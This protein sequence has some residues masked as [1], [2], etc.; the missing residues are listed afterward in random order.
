MS[1]CPSQLKSQPCTSTQV[2][3]EL[4]VAH[5]VVVKLDPVDSPVHHWPFCKTR[6]VM[7]DR[8][9]PLKS[10]TWTSTQM[11]VG[12]QV[13]HKVVF[14]DDP[15]D[16]PT[17]HCPLCNTRPAM[18]SLPSPLKSPMLMSTQVIST[19]TVKRTLPV[20]CCRAD[21]GGSAYRPDHR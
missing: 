6:P 18:S 7:S 11:T 9:S 20:A 12:L 17:H 8:P 3:A 4:K 16:R 21:N 1:D 19:A 14:S 10:P 15:V 2:T 5:K 13:A